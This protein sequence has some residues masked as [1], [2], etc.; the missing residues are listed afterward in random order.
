MKKFGLLLLAVGMMLTAGA[1]DKI[2]I[3]WDA[4]HSMKDRDLNRELTFLNNYFKKHQNV[5]VDLLMFSN[6]ELLSHTYSIKNGNWSGMRQEL[7]G[8]VYD[9]STNYDLLF[10]NKADAYFLFTDG[11]E[12]IADLDPPKDKPINII[13]STT[14]SKIT[15]LKLISDLSEG[16]FVYLTTEYDDGSSTRTESIETGSETDMVSGNIQGAEGI[17][18]NVSVINQTTSE[19]TA[20]DTQGNYSI[21]AD[22]GDILIFSYLGKKTVSIRVGKADVVNINM[23]DINQSL[24]EVVLTAEKEEEELVNTGNEMVDRKRIGYSIES[25]TDEEIS[26]LDT[27]LVGAVQGQFSNFTLSN[28][29]YNKVDI[30]NFLGRGKNMSILLNQYGLVV[31]DGVPLQQSNSANGGIASGQGESFFG[32]IRYDQD[33]IINPE[34]IINITY[35]KGLAA[36]NKYGTLGRN[37][38][39]LITT[40][41][42][43]LLNSERPKEEIPQGTTATYSGNAQA[44]SE[45]PNEPYINVLKDSKTIEQAF[46]NYLKQKEIHGDS[47]VFYLDVYDYFSDWNNPLLSERILSNI[48]EIAYDDPEALKAMAYKQQ[49]SGDHKGAVKTYERILKLE[50]KH[51][52]SYRNL[53]LALHYAG[54]VQPSLEMYKR[55][56]NNVNVGGADFS[57]LGRTLLNETKNLVNRNRSK[58]RL[59]GIDDKYM[60]PIQYKSRIVFEWNDLDA[61]FDLNVINPQNRFF[62]MSHTQAENSQLIL[63]EQQQGYALEEFYLTQGDLGEWKFNMTYYGKN[64]DDNTPTYIKITTYKDY[65][66][67]N[68]RKSIKVVRLDKEEIEQTV[69][70]LV[71]N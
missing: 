42:A 38:V 15:D 47:P 50:P 8:T 62:T 30:S 20:S 54:D 56:H 18:A 10:R 71:V 63:Q 69:A 33:N 66:S 34:L 59:T 68:Q 14:D 19:G 32:G 35:L 28:D 57:G 29:V 52:Q 5:E 9:G 65:G 4:S 64:T 60:R 48:Y 17:L 6:E 58:L 21:R 36:T 67:T 2:A 3:Y 1:Q 70:K 43:N 37:G 55:I 51:S 11:V 24:D 44:I 49:A 16:R 7:Q 40:K 23:A 41:N 31:I 13:S 53:A 46:N 27:D 26:S 25:I 61:E 12:N 39:L 22:E 45:L